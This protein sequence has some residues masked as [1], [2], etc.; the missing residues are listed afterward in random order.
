MKIWKFRRRIIS[1]YLL[2]EWVTDMLEFEFM[3]IAIIRPIA[4]EYHK[5]S[6]RMKHHCVS[7]CEGYSFIDLHVRF[8]RFDLFVGSGDQIHDGF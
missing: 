3:L 5:S 2:V 6:A 1:L 7:Y 8:G 4:F